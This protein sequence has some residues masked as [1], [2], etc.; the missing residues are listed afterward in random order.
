VT[1]ATLGTWGGRP[2]GAPG[3]PDLEWFDEFVRKVKARD[4]PPG[5]HWVRLFY[6]Q[7]DA[8]PIDFEVTRDNE[9]WG[10]LRSAMAQASWPKAKEFYSVRAFLVIQDVA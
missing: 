9:D 10:E 2:A 5:P 4:L 7:A 6:A 1:V 3:R 8:K